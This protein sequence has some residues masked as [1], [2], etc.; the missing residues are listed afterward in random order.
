MPLG[1]SVYDAKVAHYGVCDDQDFT[2]MVIV[3]SQPYTIQVFHLFSGAI[4]VA[5]TTVSHEMAKGKQI[6]QILRSGPIWLIHSVSA[7]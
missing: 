3:V 6:G 7:T 4:S 5:S 1:A 2:S